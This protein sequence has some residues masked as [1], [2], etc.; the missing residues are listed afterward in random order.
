VV[1]A[2]NGWCQCLSLKVPVIGVLKRGGGTFNGGD[3]GE[4]DATSFSL[5]RRWLGAAMGVARG[6]LPVAASGL[7]FSARGGR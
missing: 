5:Q 2:G 7:W 4:G 1:K 6:R 3:E